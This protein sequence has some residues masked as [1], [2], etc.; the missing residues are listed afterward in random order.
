MNAKEKEEIKEMIDDAIRAYN[1]RLNNCEIAGL[2]RLIYQ[3]RPKR[4]DIEKMRK[5]Y[6]QY[7][8]GKPPIMVDIKS[9]FFSLFDYIEH[10]EKENR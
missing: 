8:I 3:T 6:T 5:E 10:L 9:D 2:K 7:F 4:P 1:F